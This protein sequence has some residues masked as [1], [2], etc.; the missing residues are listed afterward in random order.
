MQGMSPRATGAAD[1][2]IP[3]ERMLLTC[4]KKNMRKLA[5]ADDIA[6]LNTR[7]RIE[8]NFGNLKQFHNLVSTVC[9]FRPRLPRQLSVLRSRLHDCLTLVS[10][11]F[12]S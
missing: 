2:Y 4:T 1:Y 3:G 9:R 8:D 6:L 12:L 10:Y 11:F 5:T 7:M